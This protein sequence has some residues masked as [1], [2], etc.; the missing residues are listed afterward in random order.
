MNEI[1]ADNLP[2]AGMSAPQDPQ[3]M[4]LNSVLL[5]RS[6]LRFE[7]RNQGESSFVVVEDPVRSKFFQIGND[8]YR[9]IASIDGKKSTREIVDALQAAGHDAVTESSA[10]AICQWL[11]NSNLAFGMEVDNARRLQ[12]QSQAINKQKMIGL[13][14]PISFKF[15]VFNPNEL[16]AKIQPMTAWIFS[17]PVFALWFVVAL[18]ALTDMWNH[19]GEVKS[20]SVGILAGG[21]WFWLLLVWF[22]L[23][24]IHEAAHGLA[25]RKY[26]GE[27]PEAGV[28]LLLF[29]PMAYVNVTSMWRFRSRWQRIVVAGAG[30]Y[31]ELF[32]AFLA[33]IGWVRLEDSILRDVCFNIFITGSL[34]TILFNANPL[35]RFDGYFVLSDILG[36]PNLYPKGTRWVGDR[37][38]SAFFGIPKTPNICPPAEFHKIAVYGVMAFCWKFLVSF[39]L[40]IGASALFNGAGVALAAVGAVLWF[41]VPLVRGIKNLFG[42]KAAHAVNKT[43]LATSLVVCGLVAASLF[44]VLRGPATKSA[45]AIV[46]FKDEVLIRADAD[47][48]VRNIAVVDGQAVQRGQVLIELEN[49]ELS[50]ELANLDHDIERSEIQIRVYRQTGESA[51]AIAEQKTLESLE[52][53]RLEK[54]DQAAGLN[55][56]APNDGFVFARN[57]S[58]KI[59][60]F[61]RRGD[62]LLNFA[63][64]QTKEIVVSV[65]QSDL[66]SIKCNRGGSLR[67]AFPGVKVVHCD[68]VRINP[69]A[70][71]TP[72]HPSLCAN[73]GGP[74]EVK[75]APATGDDQQRSF[76]LLTPRFT[77]ELKVDSTTGAMLRSGQRGRAFFAAERQSLG[78]Y[79]YLAANRWVEK[80][81]NAAMQTAA[82]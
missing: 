16:L 19:W 60:S 67:V 44:F 47:G 11:I 29:T 27:V 69:R 12:Q 21:R 2:A 24:V 31:V 33:F 17:A 18:F 73:A 62:T 59:D 46:Q 72:T 1:S 71:E 34:T 78:A 28:L 42:E 68:L 38:K 5:V 32:L 79:L 61:I 10:T 14:N 23:K 7:T 76:A 81:L 43:R 41:G 53:Q 30:M 26:G 63:Q 40:I 52:S 56:T 65:D 49:P 54:Q 15:K 75:P 22:V 37:L 20:S 55:I 8:E 77:V 35:M 36:V 82:F 6:A 9:F 74:L 70:S 80:K 3:E 64:K 48:F 50:L 39:S 4:W 66:G 25:C 57:L 45:P 13:L 58:D 51:L